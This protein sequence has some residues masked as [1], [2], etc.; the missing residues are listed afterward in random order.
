M[1][2]GICYFL[3][4]GGKRQKWRRYLSMMSVSLHSLRQWYGGPVCVLIGEDTD[5]S[6]SPV[7]YDKWLEFKADEDIVPIAP[8]PRHAAYVTKA[9][10]WRHS[11]FDRTILLDADTVVTGTIDELF[12]ES[13]T[14]TSFSHWH[15]GGKIVGG[16]LQQWA[17][18]DLHA[19]TVARIRR[20][21]QPALN[22]GVTSW[23]RTNAGRALVA[24][25]ALSTQGY[26]C[27]FT[28]E[29]AAQILAADNPEWFRVLPDSYNCSP[30]FGVNRD[31]AR[32]WHYHGRRMVR[33][34]VAGELYKP[35]LRDALDANAGGI[36]DWLKETDPA[37]WELAQ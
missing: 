20:E 7:K 18:R 25:E 33:N 37:L 23:D 13:F 11:P 9:S 19:E 21:P 6:T 36:R 32:I 1:T 10:L 22:T 15:T 26:E 2:Q 24:W 3:C 8:V 29:L 35:H 34:P 27:S 17:D 12:G 28:D 31:D 5:M 16:R 14:V 30:T 4:G